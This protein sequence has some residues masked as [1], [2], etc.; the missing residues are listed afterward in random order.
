MPKNGH[1]LSVRCFRFRH[2][3]GVSRTIGSVLIAGDNWTTVSKCVLL[4]FSWCARWRLHLLVLQGL[5]RVVG[6]FFVE[7]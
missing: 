3:A 7:R 2:H 5:T 4:A 1:G 6:V